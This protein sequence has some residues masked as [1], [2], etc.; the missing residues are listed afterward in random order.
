[1]QAAAEEDFVEPKANPLYTRWVSNKGGMVV[2]VPEEWLDKRLGQCFKSS[3]LPPSNGKLVQ[4][5]D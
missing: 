4:S 1:M 2:A 5:V 3:S